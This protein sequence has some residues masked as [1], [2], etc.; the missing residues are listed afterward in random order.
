MISKY[1]PE[2]L[3]EYKNHEYVENEYGFATFELTPDAIIIGDVYVRPDYRK[4][5]F[6]TEI[7]TDVC[8]IGRK[9]GCKHI[10]ATIYMGYAGKEIS[11]LAALKFGVKI[12][13]AGA[14]KIIVAKE[15]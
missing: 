8:A 2:Y 6:A 11:L 10:V 15:L 4:Q 9:Q 7:I 12:I 13:S 5:G 3:Q 1:Y 14:D